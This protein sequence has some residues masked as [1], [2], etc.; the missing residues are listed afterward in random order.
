[1]KPISQLHYSKIS[2]NQIARSH[3]LPALI[4]TALLSL[5]TSLVSFNT[6]V[7]APLSSGT[8]RQERSQSDRLPPQVANVVR[9]DLSR[10]TG[11]APGQLRITQ[12][13]PETWPNGCLGLAEPDQFGTPAL[14]V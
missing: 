14:V 4:L 9:Q 8:A 1:M 5:S 3:V 2:W 6:A 10:R 13:S 12:S 7:A 11:I